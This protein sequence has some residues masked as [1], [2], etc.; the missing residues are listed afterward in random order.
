MTH[1]AMNEVLEDLKAL[2]RSAEE[3]LDTT[4]H[5][6]SSAAI[7]V[8]ERATRTLQAAKQQLAGLERAAEAKAREANRYVHENPWTAIGLGA[9]VGV[10]L[11]VLIGRR[12]R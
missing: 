1:T 9:A 7:G 4:A 12:E 10:L 11:G 3:L 5:D 2:V 6:A 8:R